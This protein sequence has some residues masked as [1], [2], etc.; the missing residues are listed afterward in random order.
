[1]DP[2]LR[3]VEVLP[4]QL[5]PTWAAAVLGEDRLDRPV[6]RVF[7]DQDAVRMVRVP[8]QRAWVRVIGLAAVVRGPAPIL[9]DHPPPA[10]RAADVGAENV[11]ALR[12]R[13]GVDPVAL[14]GPLRQAPD[15][16]R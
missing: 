3:R 4:E 10:D 16:G 8:L 11:R 5:A 7:P 9:A 6:Q 13:V 14:P 15:L 2:V 1:M 12:L